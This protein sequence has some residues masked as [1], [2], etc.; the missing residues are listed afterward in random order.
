MIL[1][2][3]TGLLSCKIRATAAE[4]ASVTHKWLDLKA[5]FPCER[6]ISVCLSFET[7]TFMTV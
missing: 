2:V 7:W 1:G 3:G 5:P 6:H 4:V